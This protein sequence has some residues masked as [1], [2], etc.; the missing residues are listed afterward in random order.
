MPSSSACIDVHRRF[1]GRLRPGRAGVFG[2]APARVAVAAWLAL[3]GLRVPPAGA[4]EK[5]AVE[6]TGAA[7]TIKTPQGAPIARYVIGPLP[8][9]EPQTSVPCVGYLHP[10]YTPSGQILTE[11][12]GGD[13]SWLRGV[14]LAWPQVEGTKPG[15]F[16]T[17]GQAVWKE[18]GRIVNR[19]TEVEAAPDGGRIRAVHAWMADDVPLLTERTQ[20]NARAQGGMHVIDLDI[21]LEAAQPV[22][23]KPWAFAGLTFHGRRVGGESVAVWNPQGVA[24]LKDCAW[25]KGETNWPDAPWYDLALTGKDGKGCGLA[26]MGARSNSPTTW[27]TNRGLRFL[28]SNVTAT[29]P[30]TIKEGQ[31][32]VLRYRLVAHDGPPAI[33]PLNDLAKTL[34]IQGGK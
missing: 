29:Q 28:N 14:F 12:K 30:M 34:G 33:E 5:Y 31:P 27:H 11:S 1:L 13:H 6:K 3:T 22:T 17:C 19:E 2:D 16:W 9:A 24:S 20:V 15:G 18:K 8:P 21:R 23:L 10:I 7:V 4:E 32:L 25:N 26:M